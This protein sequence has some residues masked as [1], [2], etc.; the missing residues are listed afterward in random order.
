MVQQALQQR[1]ALRVR[2]LQVVDEQDD[3]SPS[4]QCTKQSTQGRKRETP[5]PPGVVDAALGRKVLRHDADPGQHGEQLRQKG[6]LDRQNGADIAVAKA[7]QVIGQPVH[8]AVEGLERH[9]LAMI[10]APGANQGFTTRAA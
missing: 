2:P 10:A 4:R 8:D 9:G 3:G 5:H 7:G 1:Q 6:R